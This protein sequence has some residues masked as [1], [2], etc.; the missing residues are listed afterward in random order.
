MRPVSRAA[1][2]FFAAA[3]AACSDAAQTNTPPKPPSAAPAAPAATRPSAPALPDGRALI[4]KLVDAMGGAEKFKALESI[5]IKTTTTAGTQKIAS[6]VYYAGE[7]RFV[8]RRS[9]IG[10][11]FGAGRNGEDR[12][13]KQP[14]PPNQPQGNA[15]P[16]R[17]ATLSEINRAPAE[18][19]IPIG[20]FTIANRYKSIETTGEEEIAGRRCYR[21]RLADRLDADPAEAPLES[22][23]FL[24][25]ETGLAAAIESANPR[26]RT[27]M[28]LGEW[29]KFGDLTIV[30]RL[31]LPQRTPPPGRVDP[32]PPPP[33]GIV[34]VIDSCEF[35][36]VDAAIFAVPPDLP[37]VAPAAP[38]APPTTPPGG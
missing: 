26:G 7:D 18:T 6:D 24:D 32:P 33:S 1:I 5:H 27:R 23:L 15:P 14:T 9:A 12:W 21:I 28:L 30:T 2:T 19:G 36:A 22:F 8:V 31:E 38:P 29:K 4:A 10:L 11:V 17:R 35:D 3:V 13:I 20:L 16:V 37:P 34:T 25:A